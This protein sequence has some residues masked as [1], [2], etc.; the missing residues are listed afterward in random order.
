MRPIIT[1][2]T[3]FGAGSGYVAQMKGVL[4]SICRDLDIIDVSHAIRP[5]DVRQGAILLADVTPR[6]PP[7]TIHIAVVDPGVGTPRR[8]LYAE[9]GDQRYVA[10][11]NGLLSYLATRSQLSLVLS[12]E[13]SAFWLPEPSNTFHGRDI[14]APVAA[15]VANGISPNELGPPAGSIVQLSWPHPRRISNQLIGEVL[16]VDSFGNLITNITR[17]DLG[18]WATLDALLSFEIV[19]QITQGVHSTY[20]AAESG[21]LIALFDSQG[22]LEIA[23]VGG[24]SAAELNAGPGATITVTRNPL[25]PAPTACEDTTRQ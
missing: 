16:L 24:N 22:R 13:N 10:P 19:G 8:I 4:L 6:F 7:G 11:D 18:E 20:G 9:I 3:D 23:K 21:E 5:Q 12:V 2:T 25:K 17:D 15:H 14:M 1:L